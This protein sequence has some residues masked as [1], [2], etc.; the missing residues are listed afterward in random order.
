MKRFH[1]ILSGA[2]DILSAVKLDSRLRG[3]DEQRE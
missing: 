2:K 1:V 3:N